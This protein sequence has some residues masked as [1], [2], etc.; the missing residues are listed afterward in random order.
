MRVGSAQIGR[1][2]SLERRDQL[3]LALFDERADRF[4]GLVEDVGRVQELLLQAN[5]P[6]GDPRDVEQVVDQADELPH[7][8]FDDVLGEVDILRRRRTS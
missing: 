1:C 6:A 5:L 2:V 3:V 8:A 7:L 4:D